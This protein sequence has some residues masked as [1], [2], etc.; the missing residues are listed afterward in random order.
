MSRPVS[1]EIKVGIFKQKQKNGD[2]YVFERRTLYDPKL[3][4]AKTLGTKL[5]GKIPKGQKEMIPTRPKRQSK[6]NEESTTATSATRVHY[7][8]TKI[9]EWIGRESGIDEDLR[10]VL[11]ENSANKVITIARYWL[12]NPDCPLSRLWKWQT[13][14]PTPYEDLFCRQTHHELFE[15]IGRNASAVEQYFQLRAKRSGKGDILAVDT[16]TMS[17]Y[18]ENLK[19]ARQGFNKDNDGLDTIKLLTIHSLKSRQPIAFTKQPGNIPDIISVTNVL[20]RLRWLDYSG[21]EVVTDTGFCSDANILTY[22]T[23]HVKFLTL[24]S[25]GKKWIRQEL[26]AHREEFEDINSICPWDTGIH[27]ITIPIMKE[28]SK[29]RQRKRNSVQSGDVQNHSYRLYLHIYLNPANVARDEKRLVEKLLDLKERVLKQDTKFSE[30]E[31]REIQKYLVLS[32][33]G[34]G[35]KLQVSFNSEAFKEAKKYFGFF[36]LVSNKATDAF[37]ALK[38]Y[39]LREKIEECFRAQ[40]QTDELGTTRVQYDD[41]L[42]GRLFCQFVALGYSLYWRYALAD[43]REELEA[44]P[45]QLPK[46]ER[47]Q[48]EKLLKWLKANSLTD[49]IDWVD[50]IEK[51]QFVGRKTF[52]IISETTERDQLFLKLLMK[53]KNRTDRDKNSTTD[54]KNSPPLEKK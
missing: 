37:E 8:S 44:T 26:D 1:G 45:I 31:Q 14:H 47:N 41:N 23:E 20:K 36:A 54:E 52:Q 12:A 10:K 46:A 27:G 6:E 50:C 29:V 7:G 34:R 39:R 32:K 4:Y 18:S 35:G 17:T 19:F 43:L 22:L 25:T 30:R 38:T 48:R 3:R 42:N 40:K 5:M 53:N 21:V 51:T 13:T 49:I 16:T 15:E 28:F 11:D 24:A 9:L 2:I 33:V